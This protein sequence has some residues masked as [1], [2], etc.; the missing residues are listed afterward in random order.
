MLKFVRELG[1]SGTGQHMGKYGQAA[2]R[3]ARRIQASGMPPADA[4]DEAVRSIFPNSESGRKKG[5]PRAAFLGLCEEGIVQGVP[6]GR[7]TGSKKNKAYAVAAYR[8]LVEDPRLAT[9]EGRLWCGAMQ[10]I[11][12]RPNEQMDVVL[13][14]WN[15]N[16]LAR[17][18]SK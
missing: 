16:S 12:I 5:C 17:R 1:N 9:N 15:S 8:L 10:D 2:I 3:A 14:L 18:S 4:W 11:G 7:Y 13:S 6:V